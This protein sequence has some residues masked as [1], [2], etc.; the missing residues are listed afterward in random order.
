MSKEDS[1]G[2]CYDWWKEHMK[3]GSWAM[4]FEEES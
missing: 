4:K 2:A 3:F 1:I